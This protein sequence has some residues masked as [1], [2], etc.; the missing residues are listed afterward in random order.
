MVSQNKEKTPVSDNEERIEHEHHHDEEPD[1]KRND[2][3]AHLKSITYRFR[4][5]P[6]KDELGMF[7]SRTDCSELFPMCALSSRD[8]KEV[9]RD[10][11]TEAIEHGA[12]FVSARPAIYRYR[13][14]HNFLSR[15][16]EK[17]F[18]FVLKIL[19]SYTGPSATMVPW[20]TWPFLA[21]LSIIP[22]PLCSEHLGRYLL[23]RLYEYQA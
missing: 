15:R 17:V 12:R 16:E 6:L 9:L 14:A 18:S 21:S 2:G 13:S 20:A 19:Q 22:L 4:S 11:L 10:R 1:L 7:A 8:L 23:H 3:L 5:R